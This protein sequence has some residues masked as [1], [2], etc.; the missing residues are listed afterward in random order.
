MKTI[1]T[2]PLSR[3]PSCRMPSGHGSITCICT[4]TFARMGPDTGLTW[5]RPNVCS[6]VRR[7]SRVLTPMIGSTTCPAC[8]AEP[9][10]VANLKRSICTGNPSRFKQTFSK[11]AGSRGSNFTPPNLAEKI[12]GTAGTILR[13][14]TRTAAVSASRT[15]D[16]C[17]KQP[18]MSSKPRS[19]FDNE[20]SC[21]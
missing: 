4:S 13:R 20:A 2:R 15:L 10:V 17:A 12:S 11:A 7:L 3:I 16:S 8:R 1:W 21:F 19:S 18:S 9:D 6:H 14:A 5:S